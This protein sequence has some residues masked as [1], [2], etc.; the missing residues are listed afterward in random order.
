[1]RNST[2][3]EGR[4]GWWGEEIIIEK[5]T[6]VQKM[7][8]GDWH[9]KVGSWDNNWQTGRPNKITHYTAVSVGILGSKAISW[10]KVQKTEVVSTAVRPGIGP[11]YTIALPAS[12]RQA[13]AAF[14]NR[15]SQIHRKAQ[16]SKVTKHLRKVNLL[17]RQ[18]HILSNWHLKI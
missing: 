14:Y 15:K 13:K 16:K 3:T 9:W 1:M 10:G 6:N 11:K 18:A 8:W 5:K 4:W 2:K 7:K 12:P 17:W